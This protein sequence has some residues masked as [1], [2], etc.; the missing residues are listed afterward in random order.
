MRRLIPTPGTEPLEDT[1]VDLDLA[2]EPGSPAVSLGMVSSVDGAATVAG[3]TAELGGPADKVAFRALRTAC[4]VVLVGAGT[5]RDE[6]YGPAQGGPRQQAARRA[7]GLAPAP[8]LVIVSGRLALDPAGRV[9]SSPD[10]RPLVVTHGH[11]PQDR[12]QALSAVADVLQL[13]DDEVDLAALVEHLGDLGLGRILCEG[14]PTLNGSLL[15]ADLVEE[16]FLTVA[17]VLVGGP[18]SR[19]VAGS[20][21]APARSLALVELREHGGELLLRYRR[22][23]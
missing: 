15:A 8:R 11:A 13:G 3:R 4:D 7:R 19:I 12:V 1:Y 22:Q 14:G 6:D 2:G 17:P 16:L 10:A 20:A 18:A 21:P 9:F 23:R 5:V